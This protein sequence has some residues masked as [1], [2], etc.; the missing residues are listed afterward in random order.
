MKLKKQKRLINREI[1]KFKKNNKDK[2]SPVM[3]LK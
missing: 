2:E 1:M 3:Y